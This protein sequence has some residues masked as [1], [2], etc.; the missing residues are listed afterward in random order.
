MYSDEFRFARQNEAALR[1]TLR[2]Y[3]GMGLRRLKQIRSTDR[4]FSGL[5]ENDA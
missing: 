2:V 1:R 4:F 3:R 5:I